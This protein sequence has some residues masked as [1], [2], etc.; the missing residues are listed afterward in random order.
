MI[1]IIL[2][3]SFLLESVLSN[4]VSMG[5]ILIPLFLLTSL[6]LLYPYFKNNNF[7]F[8]IICLISGILY[9]IIFSDSLFTNTLSFP[10]CGGFIILGYNYINYNIYSS[11][12]LN[13]V[14][15]ILYRIVTYLILCII[16]YISF[17]ENIL[18][19]G[20]S[21]SLLINIIFGVIMY[22]IIDKISKI[23][24]IKRVE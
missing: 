8:I 7:N 15:L 12:I 10:I 24:S 11:N 13:I 6:V 22:I 17:N 20:I 21:K 4:L 18:L 9:D 16:E 5:S 14:I 23:F 1:Y 2:I 19:S 3:V